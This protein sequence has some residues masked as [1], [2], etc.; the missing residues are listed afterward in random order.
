MGILRDRMIEEIKL[1]NFSPRT[2]QSYPFSGDW[3][4]QAL[5][6]IPESTD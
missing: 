4:G 3:P 1:R 2:Q 5:A 6:E